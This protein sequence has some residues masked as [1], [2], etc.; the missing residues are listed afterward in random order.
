MQV[1]ILLPLTI[2]DHILDDVEYIRTPNT[3]NKIITPK[4]LVVH[5][6]A[7]W[8]DT[9]AINWLTNPAAKVSAHIVLDRDGT[10]TQLAPFNVKTWHAGASYWRGYS[11]LNEHAIGIEIVNYGPT[12]LG[13]D[14]PEPRKGE[15]APVGRDAPENWMRAAHP[16]EPG[17]VQWWEKYTEEQLAVL[18]ELVPLL[19]DTYN[20]REVI[21]HEE[22]AV[23]QG[24]KTDTGP[25]FPLA[26]YKEYADH[27]NAR[28]E[29]NYLVIAD[30]LNVRG[31]P[32]TSF[33]TIDELKRGN[34]VKVIETK[35]DWSLISYDKSKRGYVYS[36][37]LLKL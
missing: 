9:S 10:L 11:G 7:T 20:I 13:K 17:R 3:D 29:G 36:T 28:G 30:T 34:N 14:K 21:S 5:F 8:T 35:N 18:D 23:P 12:P 19:V 37:F 31:G 16:L 33:E 22:I 26:D 25:A 27:G 1:P 2:K 4:F 15:R 6:T 32:G 24:R